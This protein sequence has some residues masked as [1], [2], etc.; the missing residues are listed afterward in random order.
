[1][2]KIVRMAAGLAN[3]ML[4][5]SYYVYLRKQGFD[6]YV[7]NNYRARKWKME[8]VEWDRIFPNAPIRQAPSNIIFKYGGGYSFIDKIRRKYLPILTRVCSKDTVEI[9]T[10]KELEDYGY[11]IGVMQDAKIAETVKK[12]LYKLFEFSPFDVNSKNAELEREMKS[13]NSVSLHLRRGKDYLE[14]V[15]F[16][17]TCTS[18][19]YEQAIKMIKEQIPNPIFY[20]F[21]DNPD[22]VKNNFKNYDYILVEG[23]P[24]IGWGN[25][26]DM[27][28]M[29]C[30]KHNIIANSTYSWWGAFLNPNPNKIVITPRYWFNPEILEYRN[31]PNNMVC[32]NWIVI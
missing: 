11:F 29:S 22:W 18:D 32:E 8:D 9:P 10:T 31:K 15:K 27:Q 14:N 26:Y 12:E 19:Y 4:Q 24:S 17:N 6:A 30:C 23:N 20:V 21:T 25:H 2:E 13:H 16:H 28:L 5:Y 7:D 1:M 3:R